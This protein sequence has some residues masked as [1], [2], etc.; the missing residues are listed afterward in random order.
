MTYY[1]DDFKI[2]RINKKNERDIKIALIKKKLFLSS[3]ILIL[4]LISGFYITTYAD[5]NNI[6][7]AS[8]Q[9]QSGDTLWQIAS[10]YDY[11]NIDI[12]E[13]IFN[14][15]KINNLGSGFIRPGQILEIPIY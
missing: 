14:I 4:I 3:I 15:K 7:M 10:M 9:V 13:F 6:T 1:A 11:G 5:A 8:H 2:R 12:R